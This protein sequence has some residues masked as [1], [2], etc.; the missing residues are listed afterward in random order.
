M[1]V[2]PLSTSLG[3]CAQNDQDARRL[4]VQINISYLLRAISTT[5]GMAITTVSKTRRLIISRLKMKMLRSIV[6]TG[7]AETI[8]MIVIISPF[9][10][11]TFSKNV[12][13]QNTA[14]AAK[15]Q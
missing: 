8:G 2:S 15:N 4:C 6:N 7:D 1:R 13:T 14:P 10:K 3:A 5:D 12:A 11:A 9:N